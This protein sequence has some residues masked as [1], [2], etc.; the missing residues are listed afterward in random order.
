MRISIDDANNQRI[1]LFLGEPSTV[2]YLLHFMFYDLSAHGAL[3]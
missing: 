3:L 1:G 2:G